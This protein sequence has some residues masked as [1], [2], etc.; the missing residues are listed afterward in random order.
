MRVIVHMSPGPNWQPGRNVFEQGEPIEGHLA[1][2]RAHF[3]AGRLLIGGPFRERGA[4]GI[5][6]LQVD[7]VGEAKALMDAD[8]SVI[9]GVIAYSVNQLMPV[10]DEFNGTRSAGT[11]TEVAR[12]LV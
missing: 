9:A 3:D 5:A 1:A 8:P 7:R 12:T 2:M 10:F 6:V 4:G 11:V